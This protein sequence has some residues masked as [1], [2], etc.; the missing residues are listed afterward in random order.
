MVLG[1][2]IGMTVL[3]SLTST[4]I[5]LQ[6]SSEHSFFI[7]ENITHYVLLNDWSKRF[8]PSLD[9]LGNGGQWQ[10]SLREAI[11]SDVYTHNHGIITIHLTKVE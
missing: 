8:D 9:I 10:L 6:T 2:V 5:L 4:I 1:V 3:H 7:S 11:S